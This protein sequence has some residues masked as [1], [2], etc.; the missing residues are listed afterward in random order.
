MPRSEFVC[1]LFTVGNGLD[2]LALMAIINSKHELALYDRVYESAGLKEYVLRYADGHKAAQIRYHLR[3]G[4]TI[5]KHHGSLFKDQPDEDRED[6]T[7]LACGHHNS[8]E[9][10]DHVL[11]H[12]PLSALCRQQFLTHLSAAVSL[13]VSTHIG[14]Y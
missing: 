8:I 3:T 4:T 2:H 14:T 12:C 1:E 10:V 9:S 13:I 5:P 7:C 11:L 6:R